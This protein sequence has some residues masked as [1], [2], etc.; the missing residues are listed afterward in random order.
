[1]LGHH[2]EALAALEESVTKWPK[3]KEQAAG[4][5]DFASLRDDPRFQQLIA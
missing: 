5:D 1:M 4:D 2:D 3:F